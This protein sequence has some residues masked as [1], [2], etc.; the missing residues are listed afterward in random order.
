MTL[1]LGADGTYVGDHDPATLLFAG[2]DSIT[3][4]VQGDVVPAFGTTLVAPETAVLI[5]P[6]GDAM[7]VDPSASLTVVWSGG[8]GNLLVSLRAP[9]GEAGYTETLSCTYDANVKSATIPAALLASFAD[10]EPGFF[11]VQTMSDDYVE[12]EGWL[13]GVHLS[14]LAEQPSGAHGWLSVAFQ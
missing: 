14:S 9:D 1:T 2:G 3:F 12:V 6:T 8:M 5:E 10:N 11:N 4:S 13:V 7:V